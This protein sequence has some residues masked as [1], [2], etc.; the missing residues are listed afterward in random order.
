MGQEISLEQESNCVLKEARPFR[1]G[2]ACVKIGEKWGFINTLGDFIVKLEYD[3]ARIFRNGYGAVRKNGKWGFVDKTG[4]LAIPAKYDD[5]GFFEEGL[6]SVKMGNKWGFINTSGNIVVP[7]EYEANLLF[8]MGAEHY[9]KNGYAKV[10]YSTDKGNYGLLID[11]TGKI[12]TPKGKFGAVYDYCDGLARFLV[13][14]LEN[15]KRVP[16]WGYINNTGQVVIEPE[17]DNAKDFCDGYAVVEKNN[18]VG[19]I[20]KNG[21]LVIPYKYDELW[22]NSTHPNGLAIC[23]IGKKRVLIDMTGKELIP[24]YYE[25][26]SLGMNGSTDLI[27]VEKDGKYG[28]INKNNETIIPFKF[29]NIYNFWDAEYTPAAINKKWGLINKNGQVVLKFVF[30][31][32]QGGNDGYW[33]FKYGKKFGFINKLGKTISINF[34]KDDMY[35]IAT[36]FEN[37][38]DGDELHKEYLSMA[39]GWYKKSAEKGNKY[40]CF[41]MGINYFDGGFYKPNYAEAVKWFE[42]G[43]SINGDTNGN[44]YYFLGRIYSEGGNGVVKN[45]SKA[46]NYLKDGAALKNNPECCNLL[47]YIYAQNKN[48]TE[49]LSFIDK[50]IEYSEEPANF[51]DSKGEIYLMMGRTDDA[52]NMWNKVMQIDKENIDFYKENSELYK[53]LKTKGKI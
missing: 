32:L 16:K 13:V 7:T 48:Y 51:Y 9:F 20:D 27:A 37:K 46:T 24:G 34:D 23:N 14:Y 29:D 17:Y 19:I 40:A 45:E 8:D 42:K 15:G 2:L 30:D 6:A 31:D 4:R 53:Q 49:A 39:M 26:I 18:K 25:S 11:K 43:I 47:A 21:R 22:A 35:D 38:W 41:K 36:D 52:I 50:A 12:V 10:T 44:E 1:E 33:T 3:D 28:W 5:V